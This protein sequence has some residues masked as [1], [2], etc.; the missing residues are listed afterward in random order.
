MRY[1]ESPRI[2]PDG[3]RVRE[4]MERF[5]EALTRGI[6][7][8]STL[9]LETNPH[10]SPIWIGIDWARPAETSDIKE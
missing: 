6:S 8:P 3:E 1:P 4:A 10:L 2:D 9:M 5:R 7:L